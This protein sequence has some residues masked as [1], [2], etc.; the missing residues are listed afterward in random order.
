MSLAAPN[1]NRDNFDKKTL[2]TL[3]FI[4]NQ[5][6]PASSGETFPI[7]DPTTEKEFCQVAKGTKEDVDRAVASSKKAFET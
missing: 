2:R 7:I 3:H 5:F 1:L 4:D 6:V